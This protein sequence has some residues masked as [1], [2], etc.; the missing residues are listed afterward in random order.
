MDIPISVA[1]GRL[2]ELVRRAQ[3]GDEVV[4]TRHGQPAARLVRAHRVPTSVEERAAIIEKIVR[5]ARG[6][7]APGPDAARSQDFLYEEET[8]LPK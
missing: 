6:K 1:K 7:I 5:S 3:A 2:T 8:G 4:L